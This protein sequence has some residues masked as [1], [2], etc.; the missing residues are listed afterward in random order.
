[1]DRSRKTPWLEHQRNVDG[2]SDELLLESRRAAISTLRSA[3][4]AKAGPVL[5][6]GEPGVGKT[7]VWRRLCTE[8]PA[9][10][11]WVAVD[12]SPASEPG[13]VDR[14]IGHALGLEGTSPGG[15]TRNE[16]ADFLEDR[17][18]DGQEW[19]LV[20][21][22]AQCVGPQVLDQIRILA[23]RLDR[24]DGFSGLILV[25]QTPLVRRLATRALAPLAIRLAQHVHLR[26]LDVEEAA[27][28]LDREFPG[29]GGNVDAVEIL[30][31]DAGG[32]PR[33]LLGLARLAP[34]TEIRPPL[35]PTRVLSTRPEPTPVDFAHPIPMADPDPI[36]D[37]DEPVDTP[38][39][40]S[41]KPPLRMEEG[42]IEVGWEPGVEAETPPEI[43]R[44]PAED[45]PGRQ[46]SPS[47]SSSGV[48]IIDDHYAALQAWTEWAQNQ[49]RSP[50]LQA[51][52]SELAAFDA[53]GASGR[54]DSEDSPRATPI[55]AGVWADRQQT[56]APYSQLFTRLRQPKD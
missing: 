18:A 4:V 23:N 31:R 1:M 45:L 27:S 25:G 49:G 9:S 29:L 54:M 46:S 38:V 21:D 41:A 12:L 7:W 35:G 17:A 34:R 43:V 8:L 51:S 6:T 52:S 26:P 11:R 13:D 56:F 50:S 16:I 42:L 39:L 24:V 22:E 40:G 48:E 20:I 19:V 37:W 44:R 2:P 55:Q 47:Q 28:L 15:V 33:R 53:D 32:N 30:H 10:C 14:L 5:L 3:L 36:A